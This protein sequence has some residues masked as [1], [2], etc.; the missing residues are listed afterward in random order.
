MTKGKDSKTSLVSYDGFKELDSRRSSRAISEKI[1]DDVVSYCN[2]Q[3]KYHG[4]LDSLYD[5]VSWGTGLTSYAVKRIVKDA[6][7]QGMQVNTSDRFWYDDIM[8]I[9]KLR[10]EN[11]SVRDIARMTNASTS[12]I[13]RQLKE[14]K[15]EIEY[16]QSVPDSNSESTAQFS[17]GEC[18]GLT[19]EP[20]AKLEEGLVYRIPHPASNEIC[21]Y[22][23]C[24]KSD[25]S[26][27]EMDTYNSMNHVSLEAELRK[28]P[29][30]RLEIIEGGKTS[31]RRRGIISKALDTRAGQIAAGLFVG[32]AL[33]LGLYASGNL[34]NHEEIRIGDSKPKTEETRIAKAGMGGL[35]GVMNRIKKL[36]AS[37]GDYIGAK[38]WAG[39]IGNVAEAAANYVSE[40]LEDVANSFNQRE[41]MDVVHEWNR[42]MEAGEIS[43]DDARNPM[44]PL[45]SESRAEEMIIENTASQIQ[46]AQDVYSS[47]V[48]NIVGNDFSENFSGYFPE[49]KDSSIPPAG[50][51]ESV[52]EQAAV[53]QVAKSSQEA[54]D[55][56]S[57]QPASLAKAE[58]D[59][60][61][62]S[63]N[64]GNLPS[65]LNSVVDELKRK[66]VESNVVS[67]ACL[68]E[69]FGVVPDRENYIAL[70]PCTG[71]FNINLLP[72]LRKA[73]SAE[74]T[75]I[76]N[77]CEKGGAGGNEDVFSEPP[78]IV[79]PE[80][81]VIAQAEGLCACVDSVGLKKY[82]NEE[83]T[84]LPDSP[85][86]NFG[87][88]LLDIGP[89]AN[90][91]IITEEGLMVK[92]YGRTGLIEAG[93]NELIV[94]PKNTLLDTGK[95]AVNILSG[96]TFGIVPPIGADKP[97]GIE[98]VG[99][100]FTSTGRGIY[101]IG[102]EAF[103]RDLIGG[104]LGNVWYGF[105][106]ITNAG[107]SV[108]Q[109]VWDIPELAIRI[110]ADEN[111]RRYN[112][113][114]GVGAVVEF[115]LRVVQSNGIGGDAASRVLGS[116]M[117]LGELIDSRLPLSYRLSGLPV[118]YYNTDNIDGQV[119]FKEGELVCPEDV[120]NGRNAP[121][122]SVDGLDE[123]RQCVETLLTPVVIIGET[124]GASKLFKG[125]GHKPKF[126]GG[127]VDG[128]GA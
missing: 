75:D 33:S 21:S 118:V 81:P 74:L 44:T 66:E 29:S 42:K 83:R 126:G 102:Y 104:T 77:G 38:A 117:D 57:Q 62:L 31:N 16:A 67:R 125:K 61:K 47:E 49:P 85:L 94:V 36:G 15:G 112:F 100:V 7:D 54:Q 87:N 107:N 92:P 58:F 106:A 9:H 124:C 86:G 24:E 84:A 90:Q 93:V 80:P 6:K 89:G 123:T 26:P 14:A 30:Q 35:G 69:Y 60:C 5:A 127:E 34:S 28:N 98:R 1:K 32:G 111:S 91:S 48:S 55:I 108:V 19:A 78:M 128:P 99:H 71:E 110:G 82:F 10:E 119:P 17:I 53:E 95:G 97:R 101:N 3:R 18:L 52:V 109:G 68:A 51:I 11:I 122:D 59:N 40:K 43:W 114:Q 39:D 37:L 12:T 76:I 20:F 41:Y 25:L 50:G 115:P 13:Y 45:V 65:D 63:S 27:D 121:N 73:T 23:I 2:E 4:K 70:H 113:S 22:A 46:A 105:G 120:F 96:V 103:I 56:Y 8:N 64:G 116:D 72:S 88:A 79:V